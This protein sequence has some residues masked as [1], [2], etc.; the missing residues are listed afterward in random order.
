MAGSHQKIYGPRPIMTLF[1]LSRSASDVTSCLPRWRFGL[2]S[3]ATPGSISDSGGAI[4]FRS[5]LPDVGDT[6]N[7]DRNTRLGERFLT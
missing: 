3:P 4:C 7:S 1:T 6:A 2:K 5:G